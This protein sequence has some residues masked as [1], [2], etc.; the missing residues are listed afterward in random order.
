MS[1]FLN[2]LCFLM[3]NISLAYNQSSIYFE[4]HYFK[5][6]NNYEIIIWNNSLFILDAEI[7]LH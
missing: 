1:D 3:E 4:M 7:K 6:I 2:F 5:T